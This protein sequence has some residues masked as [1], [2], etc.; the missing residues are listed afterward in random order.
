LLPHRGLQPRPCYTPSEAVE[1]VLALLYRNAPPPEAPLSSKTEE[2][3]DRNDEI[4][5]RHAA[6]ESMGQ[7]AREYDLTLQRVSQIIH[8]KRP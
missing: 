6:G 4:R 2:K 5:R 3:T 1:R 8:Q 7:L